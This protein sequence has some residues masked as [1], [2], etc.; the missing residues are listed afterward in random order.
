MLAIMSRSMNCYFLMSDDNK[1]QPSQFIGNKVTGIL[2]ENK[3]HHTTYFGTNEEYIQGIHMIPVNPVSS[4]I[5]KPEF[6]KQ[7]WEQKL[8]GLVGNLNDGWRGI[9]NVERRPF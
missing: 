4:F 2:F 7:E 1:I 3:A 9:L 6:V 5:R 8:Q